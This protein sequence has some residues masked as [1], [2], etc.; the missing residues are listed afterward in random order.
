MDADGLLVSSMIIEL[1]LSRR[2]CRVSRCTGPG[3]KVEHQV[4]C[5]DKTHGWVSQIVGSHSGSL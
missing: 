3:E 5:V 1:R 4:D 2:D